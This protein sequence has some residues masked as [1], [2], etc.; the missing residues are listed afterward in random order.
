MSEIKKKTPS[1]AHYISHLAANRTQPKY[2]SAVRGRSD[3]DT[4]PQS[5]Y[6]TAN[7]IKSY[8]RKQQTGQISTLN[9]RRQTQKIINYMIQYIKE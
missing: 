3:R 1:T 9:K 7:T 2:P 6:Q 8:H 5:E 4:A